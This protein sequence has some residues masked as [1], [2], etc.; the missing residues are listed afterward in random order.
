MSVQV[1]YSER[2][3]QELRALPRVAAQRVVQKIRFYSEQKHPLKYA[4]KL[5]PPFD[6]LYRFRVGSY[7]VIFSI[8]R[9][10][11]TEVDY[12]E[13]IKAYLISGKYHS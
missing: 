13:K 3:L 8:D 11:G 7:R 10:G 1:F 9:K 2:A 6:D 12:C 4:Q 5:K